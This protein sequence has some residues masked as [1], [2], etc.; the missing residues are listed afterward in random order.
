MLPDLSAPFFSAMLEALNRV[1]RARGYH[2]LISCYSSNHGLERDN[3][4]FLLEASIDGL[5][6]VPEDL[7]AEEFHELT[8]ECGV[9]VVLADRMIPA[10][11]TGYTVLTNNTESVYKATSASYI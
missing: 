7:S 5:I 6:Y 3:L 4:R 10:L 2:S 11:D 8:D 1:I 9:P